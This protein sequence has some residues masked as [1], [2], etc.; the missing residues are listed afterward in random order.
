MISQSQTQC[1][2]TSRLRLS[3]PVPGYSGGPCQTQPKRWVGSETTRESSDPASQEEG[4]TESSQEGSIDSR[5]Q[6]LDVWPRTRT[7]RSGWQTSALERLRLKADAAGPRSSKH[8]GGRCGEICITLFQHPYADDDEHRRDEDVS[9]RH[10]H[11]VAT[12]RN[13]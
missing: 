11:S 6:R 10:G 7:I 4:E 1:S 2:K 3:L 5:R 13:R 12:S 9:D 8:D